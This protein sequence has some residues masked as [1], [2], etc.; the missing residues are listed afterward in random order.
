MCSPPDGRTPERAWLWA[1]TLPEP[2]ARSTLPHPGQQLQGPWVPPS[3]VGRQGQQLVMPQCHV[4][5]RVP[6]LVLGVD[7]AA[8]VHQ[9]QHQPDVRL[10]HGQ[11]QRGLQ[12]VVAHI[13]VAAALGGGGTGSARGPWRALTARPWPAGV[14]C[15]HLSD[16]SLRH[17]P[18]VV[19]SSQVQGREAVLL[20]GIHQLPRP[21]QD[22]PD[23]SVGAGGRGWA[24]GIPGVARRLQE[25]GRQLCARPKLT[26]RGP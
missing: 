15:P 25:P 23:S 24:R 22:P 4:Q 11:V 19:E 12:L 13:H 10:P 1:V 16:E 2:A 8:S 20:L 6:L 7:A 9:Q 18:V 5:G 14:P 3:P 26:A 21:S 17:L